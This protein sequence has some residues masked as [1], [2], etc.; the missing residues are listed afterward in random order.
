MPTLSNYDFLW[1]PLFEDSPT[2]LILLDFS[3]DIKKLNSAAAAIY[4][5]NSVATEMNFNHCFPDLDFQEIKE[6]TINSD[7]GFKIPRFNIQHKIE[8]TVVEILFKSILIDEK[9]YILC[10]L[11]DVTE[12]ESSTRFLNFFSFIEKKL[13]PVSEPENIYSLSTQFA[14]THIADW[15]KIYLLKN[16]E[17]SENCFAPMT[18]VSTKSTFDL[19]EIIKTGAS[20]IEFVEPYSSAPVNSWIAVPIRQNKKIV[21]VF[22]LGTLHPSK[23]LDRTDLLIAE[24]LAIKMSLIIERSETSR[25]LV[26]MRDLAYLANETKTYFLANASHEIRTPLGAIL[27]FVELLS[28]PLQSAAEKKVWEQKIAGNSQHLLRIID[29][30]L[31]LSKVEAGKLEIQMG[32]VDL[33]ALLSD[34]YS[35]MSARANEKNVALKF[36]FDSAI[37]RYIYSDSTRMH[38]IVCNI[39]GN[40]IKFTDSGQVL[41]TVS[42]DISKDELESTCLQFFIKDSGPGLT[43]EQAGKLFLPFSQVDSQDHRKY[44]GTGLGLALAKRF[45]RMLDGDIELVSSELGKGSLFSVTVHPKI[46]PQLMMNIFDKNCTSVELESLEVPYHFNNLKVLIVDDAIDNQ[47]LIQQFLS[48]AG[49]K[50]E[51]A[52]NG[53][54]GMR[55]ALNG[56]YDIL[57]MDI[58]MPVKDG[59]KATDELRKLGYS[60]PIIAFTACALKEEQDR[61]SSAGFNSYIAKPVK[62]MDLLKMMAEFSSAT[63]H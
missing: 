38:Q 3:G 46:E 63:L 28:D 52:N 2:A 44:G 27:G 13:D 48:S 36:V 14:A 35:S 40:A 43:E 55:K 19:H 45:A 50:S 5:A 8:N 30:I 42:C 53:E 61:Y 39:L 34:I 22:Q 9:T 58:Q 51:T 25:K 57:L 1:K 15:A 10:H 21:G 31:D 54:E 47:I 24:E 12:A 32:R 37:P 16:R 29:D 33:G 20:K 59:Y 7:V 41:L 62:K 23:K 18:Y 49:V 60:K 11:L 6:K 4:S 17:L 26:E 56:N